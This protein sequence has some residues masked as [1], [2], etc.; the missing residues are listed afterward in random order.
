[1]RER[2]AGNGDAFEHLL[3]EIDAPARA[4]E[5]IAQQLIRRTGG[6]AEAAVHAGTQICIGLPAGSGVTDKISERGLHGTR[7]NIQEFAQQ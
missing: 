3:D 7:H 5:F 4:I 1:M 2:V 6:V